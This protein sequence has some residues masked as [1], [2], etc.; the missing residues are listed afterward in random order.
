M[1]GYSKRSLIE[2]LGIKED[3]RVSIVHAPEG[4]D[5]TLGP[6]PSGVTRMAKSGAN[7][8]FIQAFFVESKILEREFPALKQAIKPNGV[9]WISWPK[10]AAKITTDL[11][12][13]IVQDIGL[14]HGLVDIKVC[15][16]DD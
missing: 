9:I 14:K 1:P 13:N 7:L 11:T 16:V 8:D 6:L 12:G 4:Y 15:A 2:K 3:S 5:A 10:K